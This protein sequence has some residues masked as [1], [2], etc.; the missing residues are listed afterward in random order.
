MKCSPLHPSFNLVKKIKNLMIPNDDYQ[1]SH[2][3][4]EANQV[5]DGLVKHGH[6]LDVNCRIFQNLPLFLSVTF[7]VD[8]A[9]VI[10]LGVSDV[11]FSL[12]LLEGL[13]PFF[14]LKK[15]VM[16]NLTL[17][18]RQQINNRYNR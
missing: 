1:L 18:N 7:W 16:Q 13:P 5:A 6:S 9:G 2:I 14:H 15:D 3:L 11:C 4:H 10:F 17:Y 12:F 8:N